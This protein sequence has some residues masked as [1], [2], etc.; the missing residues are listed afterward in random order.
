MTEI[1]VQNP[2]ATEEDEVTEADYLATEVRLGKD[3]RRA[4]NTEASLCTWN[5]LLLRDVPKTASDVYLLVQSMTLG[6]ILW[7][8]TKGYVT[9]NESGLKTAAEENAERSTGEEEPSDHSV[10]PLFPVDGT[11]PRSYL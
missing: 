8:A 7:A 6:T 5:W 3:F 10:V 11:D 4:I 2:F 1:E 9:I